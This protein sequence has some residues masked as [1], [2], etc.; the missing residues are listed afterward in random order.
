VRAQREPARAALGELKV[1]VEKAWGELKSALASAITSS[2]DLPDGG[3]T[4]G[5]FMDGLG[6][7]RVNARVLRWGAL[8]LLGFFVVESGFAVL[9]ET[10]L[11]RRLSGPGAY[12]GGLV[13]ALLLLALV[14]WLLFRTVRPELTAGAGL[15]VAV[16]WLLLGVLLEGLI[17]RFLRGFSWQEIAARYQPTSGTWDSLIVAASLVLVPLLVGLAVVER[18]R[19]PIG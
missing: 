11:V 1:G 6:V 4:R 17:G 16:E 9:R 8:A 7:S 15:A 3:D 2:G 18:P 13:Q 14:A 12:V 10:V 19:R 5:R